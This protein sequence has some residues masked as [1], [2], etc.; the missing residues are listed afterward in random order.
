MRL[1][2]WILKLGFLSSISLNGTWNP[3][4]TNHTHANWQTIE[5]KLI[6]SFNVEVLFWTWNSYRGGYEYL[7]LVRYNAVYS[8]KVVQRFGA[9]YRLHIQ[10]RQVDQV[11]R[12]CSLLRAACWFIVWLILCPWKQGPYLSYEKSDGFHR[13]TRSYILEK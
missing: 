1:S 6:F 11:S 4:N 7:F 13:I 5:L 8:V 2:Y 3:L 12:A 10:G 9:S